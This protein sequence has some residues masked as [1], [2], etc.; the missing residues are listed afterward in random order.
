M[1]WWTAAASAK[2]ATSTAVSQSTPHSS[3]L[4]REKMSGD[5]QA[6][7]A[8]PGIGTYED[9]DNSLPT[10][11]ESLLNTKDTQRAI[12]IAKRY[13]EEG[14]CKELNL[15]R[16]ECPLMLKKDSGMNDNLDR[17]GSRTPV[18]FPAG[19]GISPRLDVQVLQAAT[20][21]KRW[22][23]KQFGCDVGEGLYTDM[24]AIRKDYFLDHDHS[25]YVDQWDWEK[26][27]TPDQ[28]NL[29]YLK[30]VVNRIWKVIKGCDT[31]LRK[32]FP[33]LNTDKYPP[34]PDK[35]KFFHAEEIL[36]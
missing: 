36:A 35:L 5:K 26:V 29:D 16:V 11:Y 28:R 6:D 7:L 24:R 33:A 17:D 12:M 30:E 27:V 18:D 2:P 31:M 25:S 8:G 20:K 14:L 4:D 22:A 34:I 9:V 19:L 23:L 3:P 13:I 10:D 1:T 21:W 15:F 32:E